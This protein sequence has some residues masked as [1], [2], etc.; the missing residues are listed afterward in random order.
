MRYYRQAEEE[1]APDIAGLSDA[2]IAVVQRTH[3]AV[4]S[5]NAARI[6]V[7]T[8]GKNVVAAVGPHKYS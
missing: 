7:V 8:L 6:V 3:I 5:E 2:L 4:H 1:T